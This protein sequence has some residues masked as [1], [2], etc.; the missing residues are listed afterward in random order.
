MSFGEAGIDESN[1]F[2]ILPACGL[3]QSQAEVGVDA[4]FNSVPI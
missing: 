4:I 2:S 3:E 1:F